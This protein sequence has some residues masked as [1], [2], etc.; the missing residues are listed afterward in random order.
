MS[1]LRLDPALPWPVLATLLAVAA[2]LAVLAIARGARGGVL[3]LL[4]FA[5]FGLVLLRPTLQHEQRR[6]LPDIGL[7]VV[8]RTPSMDLRGRAA[9]AAAAAARITA[10][11]HALPDLRLRTVTVPPGDNGTELFA[12]TDEALAEI[13]AGRL[14]GVIAITDGEV[15]DKPAHSIGAPFHVLVPARGEETDRVIRVI[16]APP[17]AIV[18]TNADITVVV[19]DHGASDDGTP[20]TL[21]VRRDGEPPGTIETT[22]GQ[23]NTISVPIRS[24]G[25]SLVSIAAAPLAG[26]VSVANNETTL[27]VNGVRDRLHVLLIS[28]EP[29]GEE[30][31]W[32]RL[33]KADPSVDLVHFTILRMPDKDDMTPLNDLALIAFPTRELFQE[34]IDGFDLIILDRFE[35]HG[36]LPSRYLANIADFVRRGGGLLIT[37]GPEFAGD[38]SLENTPLAD[39][40]PVHVP[41]DGGVVETPFR[42]TLTATGRAHPVTDQ[43]PGAGHDGGD[44]PSWGRWYRALVPDQTRGE[45]LMDGP[46]G[47]PLLVLDHAGDGRVAMLMSDQI[48]L[49]ARGEDGGGPQAE[50]LRRVAHWLMKEPDLEEERLEARI[51]DGRLRIERHTLAGSDAKAGSRPGPTVAT[52]TA[53]DGHARTV[54]LLP[55]GPGTERGEI[56]ATAPGLWRVRAAG[57]QAFALASLA[58]PLE[59]SDLRATLTRLAPVIASTGGSGRFLVPDGA[60]ALRTVEA[61]DAT[62][63]ADWIGLRRNHAHVV[64]GITATALMPPSLALL[65]LLGA[66]AV[67]WWREGRARA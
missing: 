47:S 27:T 25:P 42:P 15:H 64:T 4:G 44:A 39:V 46:N 19:E 26:E 38:G 7:L 53:P 17:Y 34:K 28:G 41:P 22:V 9:I 23:R 61:G 58:D 52:V 59:Q 16:S 66:V 35:D 31:A 30:R 57:Q 21:T 8:D 14:A 1:A 18:G 13:P 12:A 49:W 37:A 20:V 3:R 24:P 51:G 33:L 43:L 10:E 5:L 36:L 2:G 45:V 48:W 56:A 29:N 50:L 6:F 11:A 40:L 60:P 62:S 67:A 54:T 63:G 65:L 32:R 55:A